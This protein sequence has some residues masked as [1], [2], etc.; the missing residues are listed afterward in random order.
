MIEAQ[1]KVAALQ[2]E[3]LDQPARMS[4]MRVYQES[5]TSMI[6][7]LPVQSI[8]VNQVSSVSVSAVPLNASAS[9]T[10]ITAASLSRRAA[11]QQQR[12]R[13]EVASANSLPLCEEAAQNMLRIFNDA[14]INQVAAGNSGASLV[15]SGAQV[16]ATSSFNAD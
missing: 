5:P 10:I 16:S 14:T 13:L 12:L 1:A 11:L 8:N 9:E 4:V 7:D 2:A 6:D 15:D 3:F